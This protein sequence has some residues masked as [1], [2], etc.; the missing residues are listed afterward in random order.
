ME[1]DGHGEKTTG[2]LALTE[3]DDRLF[4]AVMKLLTF[5]LEIIIKVFNV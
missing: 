5:S 4:Q 3:E 1:G 2:Q